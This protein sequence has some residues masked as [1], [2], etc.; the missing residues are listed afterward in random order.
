MTRDELLQA[1]ETL[2]QR[3]AEV[4]RMKPRITTAEAVVGVVAKAKEPQSILNLDLYNEE[5][6]DYV[7]PASAAPVNISSLERWNRFDFN[8]HT[9]LAEAKTRIITWWNQEMPSGGGLILAGPNGTGKTEI[10]RAI[11]DYFGIGAAFLNELDMTTRV[12]NAYSGDGSEYSVLNP[13]KAAK[14]LIIDDLGADENCGLSWIQGIYTF[15][16]NDRKEFGRP[17]IVT[18]NL[19]L[20]RKYA[21]GG[22]EKPLEDRLGPR[23]FDRLAHQVRTA[24]NYISLLGVPSYRRKDWEE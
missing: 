5:V 16:L 7:P 4:A 20:K 12:R 8:H 3:R 11:R 17:T 6:D 2:H 19:R 14:L 24:E 15:L 22:T 18:T 21:D 10:A 13:Y 23:A 9:K 1:N